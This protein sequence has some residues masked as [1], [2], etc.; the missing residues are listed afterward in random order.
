MTAKG[1]WLAEEATPEQLGRDHSALIPTSC[2]EVSG[3]NVQHRGW[4]PERGCRG[5][6]L[7]V[8][9]FVFFLI[10]ESNVKN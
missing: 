7:L 5:V 2:S 3:C 4:R 9:L 6:F 1:L 10:Q 8:N